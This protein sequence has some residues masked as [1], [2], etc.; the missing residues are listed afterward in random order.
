MKTYNLLGRKVYIESTV[1]TPFKNTAGNML[2]Y[3]T[4]PYRIKYADN[5]KIAINGDFCSVATAKESIEF[6]NKY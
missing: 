5:N 6:H 2:P 1:R 4:K 3:K